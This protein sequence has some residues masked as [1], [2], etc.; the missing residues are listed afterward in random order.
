MSALCEVGQSLGH[1][2]VAAARAGRP[3]RSLSA[4]KRHRMPPR[5]RVTATRMLPISRPQSCTSRV[6][7]PTSHQHANLFERT[8]E[9]ARPRT[10]AI[11]DSS[12]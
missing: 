11:L 5:A 9:G 8:F 12:R 1:P 6:P 2:A 3:L 7:A 10:K 4:T